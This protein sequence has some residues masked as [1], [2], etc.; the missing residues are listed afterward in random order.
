LELPLIRWIGRISYSVYL[1]QMPFFSRHGWLSVHTTFLPLKITVIFAVA[2]L[3]Y[4]AVERPMIK[5]ARRNERKV[6]VGVMAAAAGA[7]AA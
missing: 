3:S 2:A 7:N 6:P 1:W 5:L 4:Y